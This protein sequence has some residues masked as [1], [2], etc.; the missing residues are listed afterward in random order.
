M[1]CKKVVVLTPEYHKQIIKV[2]ND[3][4]FFKNA[5]VYLKRRILDNHQGI[6]TRARVLYKE[7]HPVG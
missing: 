1:N 4:I 2:Q 5:F 7:T 3:A 6:T